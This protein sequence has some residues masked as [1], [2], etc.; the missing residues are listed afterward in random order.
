MIVKLLSL[1][2]ARNPY[3]R[4]VVF[5]INETVRLFPDRRGLV[6]EISFFVLLD[7][8]WDEIAAGLHTGKYV[9]KMAQLNGF[10]IP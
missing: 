10:R 8:V 4:S 2:P 5:A 9:D 7:N 3:V 1:Q 6:F